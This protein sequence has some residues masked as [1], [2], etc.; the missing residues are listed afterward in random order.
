[1]SD[2]PYEDIVGLP[3]HVSANRP[4]LS[5]ESRAAQF[6]PFAALTGHNAAIA[7]TARKTIGQAELSTEQLQDLSRRLA[8]AISLPEKPL[9]TITYFQP[10]NRKAGGRY[11]TVQGSVKK[12]EECYNALTLTDKTVIPLDSICAIDSPI[13]DEFDY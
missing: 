2:F 3:H 7:E 5:P 9:L 8:Y 4:R 6:A 11:V 10:D 1:M 12:V 13:F